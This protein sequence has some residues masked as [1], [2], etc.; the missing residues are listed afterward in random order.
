MDRRG[1]RSLQVCVVLVRVGAYDDPLPRQI[2]HLI[3]HIL[4]KYPIP[5]RR[6]VDHNVG[7]SSHE[8][9]VLDYRATAQACGQ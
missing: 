6:F 5:H 9:A 4:N 3:Q 7:D 1:R 8:L 2:S